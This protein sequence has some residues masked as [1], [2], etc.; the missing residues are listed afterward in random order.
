MAGESYN[1]PTGNKRIVKNTAFLYVRMLFLLL[2]NLYTARVIL[3][4]LGESDY[5]LYHVVA[6]IIVFFSVINGV[7]AAGTSRFLTYDLGKGD[8]SE[9]RKTFSAAF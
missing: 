2:I 3:N 5:G 9:L 6:G 7:L 8:F 1:T 4:A